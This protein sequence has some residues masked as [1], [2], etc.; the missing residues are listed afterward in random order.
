MNRFYLQLKENMGLSLILFIGLGVEFSN[1]QAMFFRF[2]SLYRPDWGAFN[3][4]PA[5]F[6]SAFLLLCI[7][8]FGI[9]KQTVLSWFL[10]LLTC[11]ISFSV[12]SRMKLSW[13]WENMHEIH[14]VVLILSGMLPLL[15]AYTTHQLARSEEADYYGT[16]EQ[17]RLE[18]FIREIR[19]LQMQKQHPNPKQHTAKQPNYHTNQHA[20]Q[21]NYEQHYQQHTQHEAQQPHTFNFS[22]E[23]GQGKR[24]VNYEVNQMIKPEKMPE[25]KENQFCEECN[26]TLEGKRK[27]TKYCSKEC[28]HVAQKRRK[29]AEQQAVDNQKHNLQ[30]NANVADKNQSLHNET[31]GMKQQSFVR[32]GVKTEN[33]A[34]QMTWTGI[35]ENEKHLNLDKKTTEN[36]ATKTNTLDRLTEHKVCETKQTQENMLSFN[37][38]YCGKETKQV[39]EHSRYCSEVCRI[40]ALKTKKKSDFYVK[41][42]EFET[43]GFI[44]W[45]NPAISV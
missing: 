22:Q 17:E 42:D 31:S 19:Q 27:G 30:K 33:D 28:S 3:H 6:L 4:L 21:Q 8:I 26:T 12:Y 23:E 32:Q 40:S 41:Q 13:E 16:D 29:V 15:V 43:A 1:F 2:M 44:E 39:S 35:F 9:R 34:P 25:Y 5:I 38:D 37:C 24:K 36:T 18:G 7:V 11:V 14:F 10:A 20:Y 45:K